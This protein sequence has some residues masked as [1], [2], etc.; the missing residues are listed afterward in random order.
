MLF[1]PPIEISKYVIIVV[2]YGTTLQQYRT[3]IYHRNER[4]QS[5]LKLGKT[6]YLKMYSFLCDF[7]G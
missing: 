5:Q 4:L 1:K 6:F 7:P 3:V 2:N